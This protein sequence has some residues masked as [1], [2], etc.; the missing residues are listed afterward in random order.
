MQ[1]AEIT[2]SSVWEVFISQFNEMLSKTIKVTVYRSF[3]SDFGVNCGFMN[4]H[5]LSGNIAYFYYLR[6][7]YI[8]Y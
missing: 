6:I 5:P 2:Y 3:L 4:F 7:C 1:E 8:T